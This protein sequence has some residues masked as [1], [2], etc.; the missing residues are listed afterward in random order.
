MSQNDSLLQERL[1]RLEA[2]NQQLKARLLLS[3]PTNEP[4]LN[5]SS[6]GFQLCA[7][8]APR[9]GRPGAVSR[10]G[11][12]IIVPTRHR[13]PVSQQTDHRLIGAKQSRMLT[14]KPGSEPGIKS[15]AEACKDGSCNEDNA[16]SST[17]IKQQQNGALKV[18]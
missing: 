18:K 2:E 4:D 14:Q 6:R 10:P 7:T 17:A 8:P 12:G 15:A 1:Q 16:V 3:A 11:S 9:H 5:P 13:Q